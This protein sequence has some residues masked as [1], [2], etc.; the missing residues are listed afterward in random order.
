MVTG[1]NLGRLVSYRV[2]A[3]AVSYVTPGTQFGGEPLQAFL[4]VNRESIPA[5]VAAAAVFLERAMELALNLVP[6]RRRA[7][8]AGPAAVIEVGRKDSRLKAV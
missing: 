2:A 4:L 5:D 1:I 6:G 8:L 3:G 7:A